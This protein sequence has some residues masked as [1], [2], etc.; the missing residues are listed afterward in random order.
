L[1][2]LMFQRIKLYFQ[3]SLA[4]LRRVNWPTR[5]EVINLT[6]VVVIFSII[7]MVYLGILDGIFSFLM[8]TFIF[9]I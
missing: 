1:A 2:K 3:E 6:L 8:K 5:K 7:V 9:K 4:E